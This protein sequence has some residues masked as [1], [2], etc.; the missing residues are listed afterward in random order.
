M[1]QIFPEADAAVACM[2]NGELAH[3]AAQSF[4]ELMV[5]GKTVLL[6]DIPLMDDLNENSVVK[7]VPPFNSAAYLE[8]EMEQRKY[9]L[10][11]DGV[12]T[13]QML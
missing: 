2:K 12:D 13:S 5:W 1:Q 10:E 7:Q 8:W 6:Q 3:I 11:R 4:T 9:V